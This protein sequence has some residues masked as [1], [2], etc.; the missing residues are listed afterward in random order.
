[1]RDAK[2][3]RT[4]LQL[5]PF[6]APELERLAVR[7][8]GGAEAVLV[9]VRRVVERPR[10]EHAVLTLLELYGV[11]AAM[12]RR[13]DQLTRLLDR[14][15][16]FVADVGA[17]VARPV[18]PDARAADRHLPH[19]RYMMAAPPGAVRRLACHN[20][21]RAMLRG[22][23]AAVE[24][25]VRARPSAERLLAPAV[26]FGLPALAVLVAI[27]VIRPFYG[28]MDDAALLT[29]VQDVGRNGFLD[30]YRHH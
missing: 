8:V 1:E 13:V 24:A 27:F 20:R 26:G 4:A 15:P 16:V 21:A 28:V 22:D 9:V 12:L 29:L 5:G 17:Q 10:E 2:V 23:S 19:G 6:V 3:V 25:A 11:D 30:V 18:V 7:P 14:A